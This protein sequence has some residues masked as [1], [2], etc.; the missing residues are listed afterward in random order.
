MPDPSSTNPNPN[1]NQFGSISSLL[2]EIDDFCGTRPPRKGPPK[3]HLLRD[4]LISS[5]I[6]NIASEISDT[7]ARDQIQSLASQ[8]YTNASKAISG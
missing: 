8:T 7:K 2:A 5:A 4:V 1:P 6:Y 3:P